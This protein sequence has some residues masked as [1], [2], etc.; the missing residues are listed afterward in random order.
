L[1]AVQW[2]RLQWLRHRVEPIGIASPSGFVLLR[3]AGFRQR[4]C[5]FAVSLWLPGGW[6]LSRL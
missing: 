3:P 2:L 1:N 6:G 5:F 4:L